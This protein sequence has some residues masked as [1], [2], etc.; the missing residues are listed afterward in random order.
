[1]WRRIMGLIPIN[2]FFQ[3]FTERLF[4]QRDIT[5]IVEP[6]LADPSMN[7]LKSFDNQS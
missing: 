1:M 4:C 5:K 6:C 3:A 2:I 7:V